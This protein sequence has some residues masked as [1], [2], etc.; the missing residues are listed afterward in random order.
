MGSGD[1]KRVSWDLQS[2]ELVALEVPGGFARSVEFWEVAKQGLRGLRVWG[3]RSF[4]VGNWRRC[5]KSSA[6]SRERTFRG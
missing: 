6:A 2:P 5:D 4:R 1:Q 3:S